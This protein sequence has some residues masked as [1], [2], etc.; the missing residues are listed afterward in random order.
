MDHTDQEQQ[1][2][3]TT[4]Y[5]KRHSLIQAYLN[6]HDHLYLGD[7]KVDSNIVAKRLAHIFHHKRMYDGRNPNLYILDN[8]SAR[9]MGSHTIHR[10]Q[11]AILVQEHMTPTEEGKDIPFDAY[12]LQALPTDLY[13]RRQKHLGPDPTPDIDRP[14]RQEKKLK[15]TQALKEYLGKNMPTMEPDDTIT[16]DNLITCVEHTLDQEESW[17]PTDPNN[18]EIWILT[19]HPLGEILRQLAIH[20]T[21]L[22]GALIKALT[23]DKNPTPSRPLTKKM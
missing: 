1:G 20:K 6:H 22:R 4:W 2:T 3:P 16:A 10:S 21:Q 19:S 15:M 8:E 7:R 18:T 12:H 17:I 11:L 9:I 23:T 13:K 5:F 14:N